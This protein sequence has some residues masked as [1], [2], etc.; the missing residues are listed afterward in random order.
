MKKGV[1]V[2]WC[3][4]TYSCSIPDQGHSRTT[5]WQFLSVTRLQTK[6]ALIL[7][8]FQTC[9]EE[10]YT[11]VRYS[12]SLTSFPA[13]WVQLLCTTTVL[14]TMANNAWLA[15]HQIRSSLLMLSK[16]CQSNIPSVEAWNMAHTCIY[17]PRVSSRSH[18]QGWQR[19]GEDN[20]CFEEEKYGQLKSLSFC[21]FTARG[22]V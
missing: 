7:S 10:C 15:K 9:G 1:F 21:W 6:F 18:K 4:F 8:W 13:I 17:V 2:N 14:V 16:G 22:I 3:L 19:K 11:S 20:F 5:K 12:I